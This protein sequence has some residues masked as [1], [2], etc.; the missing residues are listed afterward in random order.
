MKEQLIKVLESAKMM[1]DF[2]SKEEVLKGLHQYCC[3]D[4]TDIKHKGVYL[5]CFS[6]F[7]VLHPS[8]ALDII[9]ESVKKW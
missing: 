5:F 1:L 4:N 6:E 3:V 9:T 7:Y 2:A 8:Y